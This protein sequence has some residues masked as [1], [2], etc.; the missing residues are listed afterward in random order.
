MAAIRA[1]APQYAKLPPRCFPDELG[2][3]TEVAAETGGMT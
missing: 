1:I 2:E 3:M